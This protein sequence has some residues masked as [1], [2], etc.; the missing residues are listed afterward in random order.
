MFF[1]DFIEVSALKLNFHLQRFLAA[2][3]YKF[4]YSFNKVE[5]DLSGFQN[6]TGLTQIIYKLLINSLNRTIISGSAFSAMAIIS[7]ISTGFRLLG[8][9]SSVKTDTAFKFLRRQESFFYVL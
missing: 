4:H 3:T 6:L 2:S 1:F 8:S 7:E 5:S 9:H